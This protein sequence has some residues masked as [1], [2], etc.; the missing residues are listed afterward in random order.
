MTQPRNKVVIF[1]GPPGAGKGTQA[2][3]LAREQNLTKISTGDIL[4]DHVKRGTALGQ[5]VKPILDAGQL[6]PD[7]I[8][9][10]LIR[11]RLAGMEPVR[12]IFDGFPRTCAQAEALDMLLEE[13][14]APVSAVP[15]LE[16]PDE[17]LIERIVERG[18]QAAARGEPVRSDDTEEVARR[19]QQVYR[20]QTQ[21][22][23]DYY[24]AR[25]H[26]RHVDG[27]GTL[28]EVHD[29]IMQTMR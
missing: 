6:V 1:L 26:L 13:L 7:D 15:L 8:L 29:R 25:S 5:Q 14:G 16:V 19:R 20:E 28:D 2:E 23:I 4:R 21:P 27:V 24:G 17:T 9:I 18:R 22:L 11:D 3:R 12:V 10:A